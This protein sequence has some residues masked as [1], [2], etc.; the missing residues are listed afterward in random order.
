MKRKEENKIPVILNC[1]TGIDDAVALILAVKSNKLDIKLITTDV[2]NVATDRAALNTLN[3]LEL[4]GAPIIP[5]VAGEGKCFEIERPRVAVHGNGGLGE[6]IFEP[7]DRNV[8]QADAVDR[9][10][11]VLMSSSEPV[12][13]ICVSPTTNVAK[14]V[15]RYPKCKN[16]IA[17]VVLMAGTIE[18]VKRNEMPYPEF[19]IA[20]DPEAGVALFKSGV[21]IEIVPMEMG[22]T[23]YLTWSEV[24]KTKVKNYTGA[25]LENIYRS[26]KD[27]HVKNGIATHDGCAIA[28]V[29][30]PELF[31]TS[32]VNAK[33][34]YFDS[35]NSGVLVMDF[36]KKP[37]A[38]TCVS[39]D[40]P[41]FK[42]LYFK[43][44]SMCKKEK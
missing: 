38:I 9:M 35:I 10:Y 27:R 2:G 36:K 28:Y 6:F 41:K 40:I 31:K 4:I 20:C 15:T 34:K 26:Y 16:R 22:H 24:F 21:P 30:N 44:L 39:M 37:N 19:N 12:T 33:I 17:R 18:E 3:I 5:V 13:I 8:I 25:V 1:D 43:C 32:P 29:T 11:E 23:A 42:K 7:H 14:L